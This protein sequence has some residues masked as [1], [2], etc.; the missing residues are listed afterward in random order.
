MSIRKPMLPP[1]HPKSRRWKQRALKIIGALLGLA[2]CFDYGK[3][4]IFKK[5]LEKEF[6]QSGG[7]VSVESC[8]VSPWPLLQSHLILKN[9]HLTVDGSFLTAKQLHIRQGWLEWRSTHIQATEITG[10]GV[11][12]IQAAHG[13]LDTTD[14]QTRVA[15][16]PLILTGIQVNLPLL[17]FSGPEASLDF[18][19]DIPF[20]QLS[21]NADAPTL[22]FSNGV[23]FGF[24]AEGAVHLQAPLQGKI[25]VKFRNIDKMMKELVAAG[26][27][28]ASQAKVVSQGSDLLGRFGVHDVTLPLTLQDDVISLGPVPLFRLKITP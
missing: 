7:V 10:D 14:L 22:S 3:H 25:N 27:M 21:G 4:W 16:S 5:S 9:F 26:I 23:T 6:A 17:S 13:V 1:P 15:V 2:I 19:Y 12:I 24:T 20:R 11:A 8:K 18:L 28:E